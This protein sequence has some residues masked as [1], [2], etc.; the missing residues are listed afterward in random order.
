MSPAPTRRFAYYARL[1]ADD[2]RVYRKSDAISEVPLGDPAALRPL[3]P[4]LRAALES[5]DV[6]AVQ[7]AAGRVLRALVADLGVP[8]VA[9][10]VLEARPRGDYG[11]LHGL[12][13]YDEPGEPPRIQVWMRTAAQGRIVAWKSFIRTLL[14]ELGH[15]LDLHLLRLGETFHTHGF[16][17]RENHLFHQLEPPAGG[18]TPPATPE[19]AAAA[20]A[21][22][23]ATLGRPAPRRPRRRQLGLPGID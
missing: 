19:P 23:P 20:T 13:T 14:H 12:Y 1:G 5:G 8:A 18:K 3:L 9:L 11:E 6:R 15:H 10:E 16:Y 2:R 17:R 4:P 7:R 22:A 21:G